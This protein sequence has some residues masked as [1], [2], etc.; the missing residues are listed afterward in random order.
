M[1]ERALCA[2]AREAFGREPTQGEICKAIAAAGGHI[3][4]VTPEEQRRAQKAFKEK[5]LAE[6]AELGQCREAAVIVARNHA[7][8]RNNPLEVYNLSQKF[9]RWRNEM[10]SVHL[11]PP[12]RVKV[13]S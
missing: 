10:H 5:I 12:K 13:S 8:D 3:A 4:P 9:R 6:M 1:L 11:Q 7:A 2:W